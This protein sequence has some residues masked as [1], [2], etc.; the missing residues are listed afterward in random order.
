[1]RHRSLSVSLTA[2]AILL[3][4]AATARAEPTVIRFGFPAPPGSYL[5]IGGVEPWSKQVTADADGTLDIKVFP[6]GSV[7]N[8]ANVYDRVFN[9]VVEVGLGTVGVASVFPRTGVSTIPFVTS[10]PTVAS[11]ALWRIYAAGVTAEDYTSVRPLTL[12]AFATS[13]LHSARRIATAADLNGLKIGVQAK[14]QADMFQSL[15][16][17]PVTMTS[18]DFYQSLQR[19][20]IVGASM[21][22]AGVQVFKL[23]EV[24]HYHLNFPIGP[25]AGYIIMN[26]EAYARL[27][28]KGRE[29]I[30][31]HSG[32]AWARMIADAGIAYDADIISRVKATPG[33][34][35][36]DLTP[37]ETERWRTLLA[38]ITEEWARSTP[39]GVKV[40]EAYKR[41]V[42]A[43]LSEKR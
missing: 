32:E 14:M 31:K 34:E 8:F 10:D 26:K 4:L 12:F 16:A 33:H 35:F 13:Q 27:P 2:A 24:S 28:Q 1:M 20:L 41:E 39:D 37:Q 6:G 36:R 19:G 5:M 22:W 43:I 40:V 38:P 23:A 30:D 17:A 25:A 3:T 7:A 21:S 42:A 15:G 9:G 18:T 29:A 11:R